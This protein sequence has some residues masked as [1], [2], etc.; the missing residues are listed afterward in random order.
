MDASG[1]RTPDVKIPKPDGNDDFMVVKTMHVSL[2]VYK[3]N[4]VVCDKKLLHYLLSS[5][6]DYGRQKKE[7][8]D[9]LRHY[10]AFKKSDEE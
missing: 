2:V 6:V 7:H 9:V 10:K 5:Y 3:D 4:M 8:I 1:M